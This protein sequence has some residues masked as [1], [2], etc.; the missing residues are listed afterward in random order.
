MSGH[1]KWAK[2]HRQK[3]AT[4]AKRGAIFT[5]LG[6]LITIAA[7][8]GGDDT[9]TNFKLRLA[10]E[11]A[12]GSNMPK[13]NIERAIKRGAGTGGD[14]VV[15]EEATYEAFGPENSAFIIETITDNKNRT[16]S[17]VKIALSKNGGNLAGPGSVVWQFERKG[18]ITVNIGE[19]DADELEL[20]IIDAGAQDIST[21]DKEWEITTAPDELQAVEKA[22]KDL[23]LEIKD[24]ALGYKAK[25]EIT[26]EIE[27]K[28]EK[29]FTA[30]DD[31]D[32]V[33]N[34]YTNVA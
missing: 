20:S 17:D 26:P 34:I 27:S 24:S 3:A 4:D 21:D 1:S 7:R 33:T 31:I 2:T 12:R 28:I 18:L 30:L 29:L 22:I 13:D 16:V 8:E 11:K 9:E 14:G 5:K 6:N 23:N 10:I 25:D 32:D 15:L 19:K